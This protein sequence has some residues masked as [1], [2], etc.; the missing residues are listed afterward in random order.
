MA[1]AS[2]DPKLQ[3]AVAQ[4]GVQIKG[5]LTE[6]SPLVQQIKGVFSGAFTGLF[7]NIMSGTK[8]AKTIFLDFF[9][10]IAKGIDQ[11]V[12]KQLSDKLTNYLFGSS[13]SSGG[14]LDFGAIVLK[15]FGLGG[16]GVDVG[17][18]G[19]AIG[20]ATG[21]DYVPRDMLAYIHQGERVV[22]KADNARGA[23]G[24]LRP[25]IIQHTINAPVDSRS[26]AQVAAASMDG[27]RM[28][29]RIR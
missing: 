7:E 12:S 24:M 5:T 20:Y 17:G 4:L 29:Q 28:A 18:S 23:G 3:F 13:G 10:S 2:G 9:N 1:D 22:T 15:L 6:L 26:R 19:A 8:K 21:I 14:G 27:L 25:V 16:G 11:I